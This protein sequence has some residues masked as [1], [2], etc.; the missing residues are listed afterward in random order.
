MVQISEQ[1][2]LMRSD[3]ATL[4]AEPAK[5]HRMYLKRLHA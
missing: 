4:G 1:T 3:V 5:V 2:D